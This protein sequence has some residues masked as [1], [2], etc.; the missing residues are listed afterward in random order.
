MNRYPYKM[1]NSE[2]KCNEIAKL[3]LK[4][5][6]IF[7]RN[8]PLLWHNLFSHSQ[9]IPETKRKVLKYFMIHRYS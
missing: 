2:M 3:I 1:N 8:F 4:V 6:N 9:N 5:N 7:Y